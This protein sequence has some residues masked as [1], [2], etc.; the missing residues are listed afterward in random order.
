MELGVV[1]LPEYRSRLPVA[2]GAARRKP[3]VVDI[4]AEP[5]VRWRNLLAVVHEREQ[6]IATCRCQLRDDCRPRFLAISI[7][8]EV[9]LLQF[10]QT[11]EPEQLLVDLDLVVVI[12][13]GGAGSE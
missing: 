12:G 11:C 5:V 13:P 8:I 3:L 1:L 9:R 4:S 10:A 2:P 6:R 7:R